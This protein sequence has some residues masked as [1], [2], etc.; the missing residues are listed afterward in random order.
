MLPLSRELLFLDVASEPVVLTLLSWDGS[1]P[2]ALLTDPKMKVELRSLTIVWSSDDATSEFTM[3]VGLVFFV[4]GLI[5][6]LKM[7][8]NKICR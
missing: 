3:F 4:T 1:W 6:T 5:L 7:G 8:S 2:G